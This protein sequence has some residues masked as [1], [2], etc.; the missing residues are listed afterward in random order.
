MLTGFHLV[1]AQ[2]CPRWR[3]YCVA[4]LCLLSASLTLRA[5]ITEWTTTVQPGHFLLE[6]DALSLTIDREPGLKYTAFGAASTFL[7]TGLTKNLDIQVDAEFY[8][9]QKFDGPGSRIGR[10]EWEMFMFG[11]SGGSTSRRTPT[12][13]SR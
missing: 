4:L 11:A 2:F 9:A 5:Q 13:P 8:I 1:R 3:R 10:A 7:T 12:P 6:V